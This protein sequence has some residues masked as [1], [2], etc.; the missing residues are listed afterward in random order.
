[1]TFL[2]ISEALLEKVAAP[3]LPNAPN[4]YSA[5][6]QDQ[7]NNVL[8]LFFNRFI[9][10]FDQ[11]N[12]SFSYIPALFVYTVS[13]LPTASVAGVGA[14]AFVSDATATTFAST[15]VGGGANKVPVYS[16]GINWKIG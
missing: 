8:R 10:V 2:V 5:R 14:R 12:S 3:N 4:E 11:L 15:V 16:D 13:T 9:G 7:N 6:Y 1:M